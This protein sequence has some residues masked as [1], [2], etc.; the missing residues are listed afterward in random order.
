[1]WS[2]RHRRSRLARL[3][4]AVA[5]AA[6]AATG[7]AATPAQAD[8][9]GYVSAFL[10]DVIIGADGSPGKAVPLFVDGEGTVNPV[11]TVDLSGLEGVATA[12]FP[13]ERCKVAGGKATC[14]LPDTV[15]FFD[16]IPVV[17]RPV[18]GVADGAEGTIT[19]TAT[20]EGF[21]GSETE[22]VTLT[23]KDGVDLVAFAGAP[24]TA[25][26]G[27]AYGA[28]VEFGN[29]G[30]RPA[31]TINLLLTF[32]NGLIPAEYENCEYGEDPRLNSTLALCQIDG[33]FEVGTVY[34]LEGG[35]ETAVAP[36]ALGL[37]TVDFLAL[38]AGEA[39]A[40][41]RFKLAGK[42]GEKLTAAP[43]KSLAKAEA[44]EIDSRD[45]YAYEEV[46]VEN[47]FDLAAIGANLTGAVGDVVKAKV[48]IKNAGAGTLDSSRSQTPVF[49][50]TVAV[51][52]GA[53]VV[54]VPKV[55]QAVIEDGDGNNHREPGK[56]GE[57]YYT[58]HN[59]ATLFR[60]GETYLV[61][62][63]MKIKSLDAAPGAVSLD[64]KY[65]TPPA[66]DDDD[67]GN[68][69]AAITVGTGAGTGNGGNGNG[70]NGSGGEGAGE[71]EGLP[72]TGVQ[73]GAIAGGGAALL[74]AGV[75]LFLASRRRRVTVVADESDD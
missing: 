10:D 75:V 18:D 45:N 47:A 42:G 65:G 6:A 74:A 51:P 22:P 73:V 56:A 46:T 58:C 34:E 44:G 12:E 4:V 1:M 29:F 55:C 27:D 72:V 28:P 25:K 41:A 3:I 70:G 21:G 23:V 52:A 26:P 50:F 54:S 60:G 61:E 31:E 49:R 64:D 37:E 68:N 63:G 43:K 9:D 19:Y 36:D 7:V 5:V 48:G 69:T 11:V 15:Q 20:A 35:F 17:F 57:S 38:P 30:N 16:V 8:A 71:G 2:D 62:F 24:Q 14:S 67:N 39:D 32:S 13:D 33:P 40:P 53:E 59:P 66:W